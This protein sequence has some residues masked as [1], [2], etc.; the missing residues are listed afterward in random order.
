MI[1]TAASVIS[2]ISGEVITGG[3]MV[4]M[5]KVAGLLTS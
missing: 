4:G 1:G 3:K 2:G 5:P